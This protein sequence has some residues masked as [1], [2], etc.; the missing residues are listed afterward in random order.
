MIVNADDYGYSESV[1]EAIRICFS[2]LSAASLRG[3][4]EEIYQS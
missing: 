1:N 3:R 2:P 4:L